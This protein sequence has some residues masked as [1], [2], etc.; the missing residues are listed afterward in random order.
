MW[1]ALLS[2]RNSLYG[3]Q[4]WWKRT[5]F[6]STDSV[7]IIVTLFPHIDGHEIFYINFWITCR[8]SH[9]N[10]MSFWATGQLY[11]IPALPA[12][13]CTTHEYTMCNYSPL[14]CLSIC[15]L[16]FLAKLQR[17]QIISIKNKHAFYEINC[18]FHLD[19]V[20]YGC[21]HSY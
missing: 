2:I 15:M 11:T 21:K 17:V 12:Q 1:W 4:N 20:K 14:T 10:V 8:L 5:Y 16:S 9:Y 19:L 18:T 7:K 3:L 6:L 13:E